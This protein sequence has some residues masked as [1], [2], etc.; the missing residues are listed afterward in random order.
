MARTV[1]I[2]LAALLLA[3][4]VGSNQAVA[5]QTATPA[6]GQ[7][8]RGETLLEVQASG[9]VRLAPDM[10][11]LNVGVVSTGSTAREATDG[12]ARQ[13]TN[14]VA[15]LRKAGV[16]A[17]DIRTQQ[18]VVEPRFAREGPADYEGQARIT[19][20]VSRNSVLVTVLRLSSAPDVI[21]AAFGAGAN[22]VQGPNLQTR[23]PL[24]GM[25]E[26]RRQAIDNARRQADDYAAGLGLKVGRVLRVSE[27][28]SAVRPI[29]E[30]MVVTGSR[31]SIDAPAE[32]LA[33]P[34]S[35]GELVRTTDIWIDYALVPR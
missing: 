5:Q 33:P 2:G 30:D 35:A 23:N 7:P 3:S 13:M 18:I 29:S 31:L 32:P 20:Y 11:T 28:G 15:A 4:V 27:R 17:K 26:A 1:N 12:N 14:V 22:S 10:A 25:Q 24:L 19:G 21:A 8:E 6:V 16:E 9:Q 34:L